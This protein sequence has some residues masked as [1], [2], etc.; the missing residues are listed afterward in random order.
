MAATPDILKF[1]KGFDVNQNEIM[2][3]PVR[4]KKRRLDHLSWDEK[5]QRKKLKNRVAAQTS[6]DRKK[7][8]IEQMESALSDLCAKNEAL[9]SECENL[10]AI[11][12]RLSAENAELQARLTE[13]CL[14]CKQNRSVGCETINGSAESFLQPQGMV[15]HPAAAL[16][17]TQTEALLKIVL[18]CLLYRTCSTS[19]TKTSI[20]DRWSNLHRVSLKISPEIWKRL[21]KR[22]IIKNQTL[23]DKGVLGKWW[24]KHQ[25]SWNPMEVLC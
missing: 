19:L 8:R 3:V 7:A 11:N 20:L 4:A 23:V 16:P 14:S 2:E 9:L 24:G 18:A 10:K 17:Q 13:P 1:F 5:I 6:R 15:T 25:K 12:E 22:Q 21:L